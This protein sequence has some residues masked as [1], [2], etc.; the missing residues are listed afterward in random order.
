MNLY[1]FP[2]LLSDVENIPVK[3]FIA[4]AGTNITI[5][6]PGVNEHSLVD[7]LTWKTSTTVAEFVNGIP[8]VHNQRVSDD[9]GDETRGQMWQK[10]TTHQEGRPQQDDDGADS[11]LMISR[12][13]LMVHPFVFMIH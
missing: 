1:N 2:L 11:K 9:A 8:L 3:N 12:V 7:T 10:H 5:P 6:C 4:V 13:A